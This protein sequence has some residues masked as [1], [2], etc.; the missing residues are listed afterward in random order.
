MIVISVSI[1]SKHV[2]NILIQTTRRGQTFKVKLGKYAWA[3]ISHVPMEI[4]TT[5]REI[6]FIWAYCIIALPN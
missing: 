5:L 3:C 6:H 2:R 4:V 1:K